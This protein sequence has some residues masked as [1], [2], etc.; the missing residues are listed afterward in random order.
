MLSNIKSLKILN[1]IIG[2][3][4]KR[5]ELKLFKYNNKMLNKLNITKEDFEQFI[6]IKE[7]NMKFN[8]NVK[9]IDIED[10]NLR[11]KNFN[12]SNMEYLN[13]IQFN[14]LKVLNLKKK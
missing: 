13:K 1:I 14:N 7:M 11:N 12:D 4:R 10:L 9:D 6:L 8:L 3:L 5:I 2:I